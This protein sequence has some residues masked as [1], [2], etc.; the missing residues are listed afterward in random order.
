M[1][2]PLFKES[3]KFLLSD[4]GRDEEC[5]WCNVHTMC[6]V[7]GGKRELCAVLYVCLFPAVNILTQ[8]QGNKNA[9]TQT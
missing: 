6:P 9:A 5:L 3:M 1:E 7:V 4:L 8:A 2:I